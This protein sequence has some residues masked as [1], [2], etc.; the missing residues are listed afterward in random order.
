MTMSNIK[1]KS[2][3]TSTAISEF[4]QLA[5]E[6][7]VPLRWI[8]AHKGYDGNEKADSLT[9]KGSDNLDNYQK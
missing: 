4:N 8:P 9:K 1:V 3:S 5:M 6:N 7:Q 2:N